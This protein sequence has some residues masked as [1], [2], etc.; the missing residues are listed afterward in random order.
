M[1]QGEYTW[2][3]AADDLD[4]IAHNLSSEDYDKY[5]IKKLRRAAYFLHQAAKHQET[6]GKQ[7]ETMKEQE[8]KEAYVKAESGNSKSYVSLES[9]D[10]LGIKAREL[11]KLWKQP[12]NVVDFV[13]GLKQLVKDTGITLVSNDFGDPYLVSLEEPD[14]AIGLIAASD[15]TD[16]TEFFTWGRRS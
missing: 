4:Y 11:T 2:E 5:D 1:K 12:Q 9:C 15:G 6:E 16:K 8:D 3:M 10:K 13:L 14:A 7:E